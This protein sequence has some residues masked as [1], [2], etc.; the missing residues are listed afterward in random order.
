MLK[1]VYP[2]QGMFMNCTKD[3]YIR[4]AI[5]MNKFIQEFVSDKLVQI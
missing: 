3:I 5:I 1:Y 2:R 4:C